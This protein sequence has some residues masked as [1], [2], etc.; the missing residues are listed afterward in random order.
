GE[1][2]AEFSHELIRQ[3]VY[4]LA[5]PVRTQL[6]ESAFRVL[7]ARGVNPAEAADHAVAARLSGDLQAQDVVARA[8][9]EA[10]RAGAVGAARRHLRGGGALAGPA[11]PGGLVFGLGRALIRAGDPGGGV[12]RYEELLARTDLPGDT[13]LAVLGQLSQARLYAGQT[14]EAEAAM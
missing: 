12:A 4:E 14:A 6:H 1:G 2:W 5:A 8:G 9:R 7:A 3:A 11:P 13:R 10:L